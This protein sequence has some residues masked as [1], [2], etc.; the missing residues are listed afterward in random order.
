[1]KPNPLLDKSF[2]FSVQV[3]EFCYSIQ[4]YEKEYIISKQLMRSGTSIGAN[5]EESQGAISKADFISKL[6]I[7]LKEARES[8]YWLR[9]L[10]EVEPFNNKL[11]SI[12]SLLNQCNQITYLLTAILKSTKENLIKN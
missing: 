5:I 8:I 2:N 1:M 9:I 11:E 3:V 12:E 6:H 7:S 4:Q 10:K